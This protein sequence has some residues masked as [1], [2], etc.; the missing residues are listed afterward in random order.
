M[1]RLIGTVV[2]LITLMSNAKAQATTPEVQASQIAQKM[3]DSLSLSDQ[4]KSQVEAAT[5]DVQNMKA[6]LRQL[7]NS[8]ALDYYLLM[9]EDNRDTVYKNLLPPDKYLLFRQK[10]TTLLGN[11]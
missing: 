9:A 1:K 11:N 8:R 10:K 7:Y 5:L 3:K 4:Q 2:V 6:N